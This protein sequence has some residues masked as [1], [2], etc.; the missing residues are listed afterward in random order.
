[1]SCIEA[2]R[3]AVLGGHLDVC[4]ACGYESAPAYN[5]CR[6]RNCP[7][8]QAR[9]L[10]RR[11]ARMLPVACVHVVFTLPGEL[12]AVALRN[13]KPLFNILFAAAAQTLLE[14]GR[15]PQRL[16]ALR[17]I[18]A[19]LHTWTRDLRFHPHLH[20]VVT[21]G[22]LTPDAHPLGRLPPQVPLPRRGPVDALPREIPGRAGAAP[23]RRCTRPAR[24]R[25][26]GTGLRPAAHDAVLEVV[27]RLRQAALRRTRSR[28]RIPRTLHPPRRHLQPP[29]ARRH[30]RR[31]HHRH[32]R[33]AARDI[34]TVRL[35]PP[36]LAARGAHRFRADPALRFVGV[37]QRQHQVARRAP[38][39]RTRRPRPPPRPRR[40]PTRRRLA[41]AARAPPAPRN[42]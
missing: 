5:S 33:R 20:C 9:W 15:N 31:G 3:T 40:R 34:A 27:G 7:T 4:A 25:R 8:C 21:A 23:P 22:G 32:P 29:P 13:R 37:R 6:N 42:R 16:G 36:L 10:A 24:D 2:C 19:V 41:P 30:R 12:K 38:A 39:L 26:N 35:H 1:M 18:T 14:L 28:L 11:R 17:G